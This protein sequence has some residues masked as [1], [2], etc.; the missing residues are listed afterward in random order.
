MP[1]TT[2]IPQFRSN[3]LIKMENKTTKISN[4]LAVII[5]GGTIISS[6][7]YASRVIITRDEFKEEF[8]SYKLAQDSKLRISQEAQEK[9]L[10]EYIMNAATCAADR[11][12]EKTIKKWLALVGKGKGIEKYNDD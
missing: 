12:A 11:A 7:V 6:V 2:L 10:Q 5:A 9:Y 8:E 3:R 1:L 4:V